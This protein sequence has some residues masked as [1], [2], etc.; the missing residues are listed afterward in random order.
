MLLNRTAGSEF[1]G[2]VLLVWVGCGSV[3]W[4]NLYQWPAT[5]LL[6]AL[7]FGASVYLAIRLFGRISGAHINPAVSIAFWTMGKLPARQLPAYIVS[8]VLGAL[9]GAALLALMYPEYVNLTTTRFSVPLYQGLGLEF[10]FTLLLMLAILVTGRRPGKK[11]WVAPV[12]GLAVFLGAWLSGPPTGGS[13]NPART[14]GPAI[15]SGR[16]EAIGWYMLST[17]SGAIAAVIIFQL[18]QHAYA[19]YSR[20]V[21][22]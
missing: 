14:L 15:I 11:T 18:Q 16:W 12:V 5:P 9:T 2:T 20:T 6:I 13:M 19:K 21:H 3:I 7:F 17:I 8:Q 10:F 22:R 4:A 1:L